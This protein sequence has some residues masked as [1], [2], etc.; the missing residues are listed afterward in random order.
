MN[1]KEKRICLAKLATSI[2]YVMEKM[3]DINPTTLSR[4]YEKSKLSYNK[5]NMTL[6]DMESTLNHIYDVR[7]SR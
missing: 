3:K 1:S 6:R 5:I 2:A 7:G 4:H